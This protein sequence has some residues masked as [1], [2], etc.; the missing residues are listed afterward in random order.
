MSRKTM[1][2]LPLALVA[3]GTV[4]LATA[5]PASAGGGTTCAFSRTTTAQVSSVSMPDPVRAGSSVSGTVTIDRL[6]ESTGPVE[7]KLLNGSWTRTYLCVTV[8]SGASRASFDV[9]ISP[10]TSEENYAT[11][12]A[13]A[14]PE[15][16][17]VH[18][19]TSL[20]VPQ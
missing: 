10:V 1:L 6:P 17:D 4:G 3:A 20:I 9:D 13:Y 16:A 5:A 8:P 2:A 11:V 15:G 19:A 14:T 7:I 12:G 18:Y